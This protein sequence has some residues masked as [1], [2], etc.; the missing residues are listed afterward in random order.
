ME[1]INV[2]KHSDLQPISLDDAGIDF[3]DDLN[4]LKDDDDFG[5]DLLINPN[6][7][8]ASPP[9]HSV[10]EP[11]RPR[12]PIIQSDNT[13]SVNLGNLDD[14]VFKL[15]DNDGPTIP[16][17]NFGSSSN[18][19]RPSS[20]PVND[21]FSQGSAS[22]NNSSTHH[23]Y[24]EERGMDKFEL[25]CQLE[26]LEKRGE[27]LSKNY[28]MD[29]DYDE[30]KREYD[31]IVKSK[32]IEKSVR[33]QRKML[34]A[35]V[36]GVEFLNSKFD[37][38]DLK[39]DGW[40]ESVHENIDDYDDIFEELHEKYKSKASMPPELRLLFMLGGSGFMFHL[41]QSMLSSNFIGQVMKQN[42][43]VMNQLGKAAVN[44][45]KQNGSSGFGNFMGDILG[46]GG[47][48]VPTA[49]A[50]GGRPEMRGPPNL[51]DILRDVK[52]SPSGGGGINIDDI[53][54]FSESDLESTK[55]I[56]IKRTQKNKRE[57]TLDI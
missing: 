33:F 10:S 22:N 14:D 15:D 25:L 35:F 12:T 57:V 45:M 46:G 19:T 36:T 3:G 41:T 21:F 6:K 53:S 56:Q 34:V 8:P 44:T 23:S 2:S 47:G 1:E 28:T 51:D 37:P 50:T 13:M 27:K 26:R 52:S 29:S 54:N 38:L 55:G 40:S 16:E 49:P 48:G 30:M 42:P 18:N 5:L 32:E 20:R 11:E 7:R 17:L 4:I 31:R 24:A 9:R 43:D 39:L